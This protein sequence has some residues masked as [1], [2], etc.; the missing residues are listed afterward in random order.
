MEEKEF[1][2]NQYND[3]KYIIA[4]KHE[5]KMTNFQEMVTFSQQHAE[6]YSVVSQ[7]MWIHVQPF[8]LPVLIVSVALAL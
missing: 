4:E 2:V 3:Y 6:R 7:Y 1:I 8:R 5:A